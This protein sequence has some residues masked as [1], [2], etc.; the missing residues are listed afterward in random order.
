MSINF[1]LIEAIQA[2][3]EVGKTIEHLEKII[4]GQES[5]ISHWRTTANELERKLE[6][7]E[8]LC[9]YEASRRDELDTKLGETLQINE[10]LRLARHEEATKYEKVCAEL[11][12]AHEELEA[13]KAK[14]TGIR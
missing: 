1:K 4:Q 10:N 12:E 13:V 5:D 6:A 2:V 14:L 7:S 9:K 8:K 3:A 11:T